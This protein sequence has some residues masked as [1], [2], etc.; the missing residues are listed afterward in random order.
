MNFETF[1]NQYLLSYTDTIG[2]RV[3]M[4]FRQTFRNAD[5]G[6]IYDMVLDEIKKDSTFR[7]ISGNEVWELKGVRILN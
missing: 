6:K 2:K 5:D 4:N 7:I 1:F 3:I